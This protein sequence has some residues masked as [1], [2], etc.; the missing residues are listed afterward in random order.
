MVDAETVFAP[1]AE[2]GLGVNGAV[3]MIMQIGALGHAGEKSAERERVGAHA[4]QS[5]RGALFGGRLGGGGA[6]GRAP[7]EDE[8]DGGKGEAECE[9]GAWSQSTTNK[10]LIS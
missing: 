7:G 9:G 10:W 5:L 1:D 8:D 4:V 6:K 2:K 3:Q